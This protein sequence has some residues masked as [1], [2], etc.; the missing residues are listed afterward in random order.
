M[1]KPEAARYRTTNWKSYNDALRRRGS[2]LIWLDKD[3]GWLADRAGRPGRPPVFSDAAI[4]FCLMVKVLFG[5][6]LRQSTGM[7]ASILEMAGLD[8]PVPDFSTL[9]LRQKILSVQI[10]QRRAPGSLNLLVD[11]EAQAPS[12]RAPRRMGSSFWGEEGPWPQWGRASP[13]NANGWP[14]S[15]APTAGANT[16]RSIWPWTQP[17]VTSEV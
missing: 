4:Q 12:V 8:W 16:A 1:S 13:M 7:V 2:L 3:M 10:P 17:P 14:A 11:N 5:L 9:S 15:T 6:P